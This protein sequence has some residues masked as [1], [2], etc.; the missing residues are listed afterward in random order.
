MLGAGGA[1][2]A[3]AMAIAE[4]GPASLAIADPDAT[5][6]V[7]LV[8]AVSLEF[9]ALRVVAVLGESDVLVNCSPVGMGQ[10]DRLPLPTAL[11]PVRGAVYDIVNR[12]DTPL[13]DAAR[14]RGCIVGH[15]RSM[16]LAQVGLLIRFLFD[17]A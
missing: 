13:L 16:M 5:R 6:A 10:D 9:P 15:G 2:R 1:G 14:E 3:V 11:I 7:A 17:P 4:A 8:E 12:A